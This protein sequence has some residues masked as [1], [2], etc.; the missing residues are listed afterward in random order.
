VAEDYMR[1]ICPNCS[2]QYEVDPAV[3][4]SE[5]RDVQCSDCEH[6]WFQASS[7]AQEQDAPIELPQTEVPQTQPT[8]T[9]QEQEDAPATAIAG[10][11]QR[12]AVSQSVRDILRSEAEFD[13]HLRDTSASALETQPDLGLD[14]SQSFDI[15]PPKAAPQA[16]IETHTE[17]D[18]SQNDAAPKASTDDLLPDVEDLNSSL[19]ASQDA[20]STPRST[21]SFMV[22]FATFLIA[23]CC[24]IALYV[25]APELSEKSPSLRPLLESYIAKA[26]ALRAWMDTSFE[27][28]AHRA[29]DLLG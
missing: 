20:Q 16:S 12:S 29:Q 10:P 3:I 21:S 23:A 24:L 9:P 26:D 11:K 13:Q 28:L 27:A 19:T 1:L 6:T 2:A 15:T 18:T 5:G 25:F 14:D 17:G 4:P 22:T 8:D 7:S